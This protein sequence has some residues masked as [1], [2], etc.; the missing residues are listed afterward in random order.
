MPIVYYQTACQHL[1]LFVLILEF[2]AFIILLGLFSY[3]AQ[4]CCKSWRRRNQQSVRHMESELRDIE[5]LLSEDLDKATEAKLV[6]RRHE[7]LRTLAVHYPTTT[8]RKY[9]LRTIPQTVKSEYFDPQTVDNHQ[10]PTE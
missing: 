10:E 4:K 6:L 5:H 7:I 3:Y 8:K 2:T 1:A 9:E